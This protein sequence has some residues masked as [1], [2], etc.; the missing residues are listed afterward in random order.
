MKTVWQIGDCV[1]CLGSKIAFRRTCAIAVLLALTSAA[2]AQDTI[3]I[4]RTNRSI[5]QPEMEAQI[6]QPSGFVAAD[7]MLGD[8]GGW[9]ER[10]FA[11]GVEV[12]AFDNSIFNG[13][14]SGGIHPGHDTIVNDAFVG[15]KFDFEK[16]VG[17]KGGLSVASGIDR[18]AEDLTEKYVAG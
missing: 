10:L 2:L 14:V 9:R 12:F 16:L 11:A 6:E 3:P 1:I 5:L 15:W 17:W 18:A 13:N 8:R 4:S 7:H